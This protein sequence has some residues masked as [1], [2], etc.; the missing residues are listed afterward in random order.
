MAGCPYNIT[1]PPAVIETELDLGSL[2][3]TLAGQSD[4]AKYEAVLVK[5]VNRCVTVC[6]TLHSTPRTCNDMGICRVYTSIGPFCHCQN[7]D[8][9]WYLG[10]ECSLPI[11]RTAFY[12]GLSVTLA[13]L[14]VTV[15]AL[16]ACVL[17]NK[18]KQTLTRDIKNQ[19]VNQWLTKD[20]QW[21]RP[22]SVN[23]TLNAGEYKNPSFKHEE[24]AIH[25][26]MPGVH[27]RPAPVYQ[28]NG[29]SMDTRGRQWSPSEATYPPSQT[30][31]GHNRPL[32][33][34][35]LSQSIS[36]NLRDCSSNLMR[37]NRP[38]I[39]RPQINRPQIN[40]PQ[41]NRPQINRPQ[42]NR[43]QISRPQIRT[44]WDA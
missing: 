1:D 25:M 24:S 10:D 16:T 19:Q 12:V 30:A 32:S 8:S 26:E 22:N 37:I 3:K 44:S 7:L 5:G 15:G 13:C 18:R 21:S 2:C 41:I 40:R 6:N 42:I 11:L 14:L 23:D 20:F 29:P 31:Y 38:Q 35:E 28:L 17:F 39:N 27:R 4:A 33:N 43:P 9:T 34:A 36:L